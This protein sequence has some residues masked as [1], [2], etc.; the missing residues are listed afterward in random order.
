MKKSG[1]SKRFISYKEVYA[2]K[3]RIKEIFDVSGENS[4]LMDISGYCII[5]LIAIQIDPPPH[6]INEDNTV[7]Y[8]FYEYDYGNSSWRPSNAFYI[9]AAHDYMERR[10]GR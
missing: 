6:P 1:Y 7:D 10:R 9:K 5:N 2:D 8:A 4:F 3:M